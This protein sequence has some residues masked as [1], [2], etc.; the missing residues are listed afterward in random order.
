VKIFESASRVAF[1]LIT[2]SACV[3]FFIG[4]LEADSFMVL[5]G[6]AFGYFFG[7]NKGNGNKESVDEFLG[8]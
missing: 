4:I 7:R 3:G 5:A 6:A 2:V 1:L 8:D